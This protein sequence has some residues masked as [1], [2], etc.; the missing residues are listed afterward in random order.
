[1]SLTFLLGRTVTATTV[2]FAEFKNS[3]RVCVSFTRTRQLFNENYFVPPGE[4]HNAIEAPKGEMTVYLVS[5]KIRAP[6]FA[7]LAGADFMMRHHMLAD[8][9]AITGTMDL[10][11]GVPPNSS[12]TF[13]AK[14]R[15]DT[16]VV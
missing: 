5:C 4:T 15:P 3:A 13:S 9:V 11:F 8:A 10:L 16:I 6:G 7:H 12:E 1:S 14:R 2:I